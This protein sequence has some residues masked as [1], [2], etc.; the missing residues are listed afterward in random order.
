[1]RLSDLERGVLFALA[2]TGI[3]TYKVVGD[4]DVPSTDRTELVAALEALR[5]RN[6]VYSTIEYVGHPLNRQGRWWA[7]TDEGWDLLGMI[8]SPRYR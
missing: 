3:P 4:P 8:K 2:Q 1:V 6:L 5:R 7:I